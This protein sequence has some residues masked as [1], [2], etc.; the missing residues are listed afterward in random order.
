[1]LGVRCS[2][3]P[4]LRSWILATSLLLSASAS[5]SP[6]WWTA[7]SVL[8]TN[9]VPNDYAAVNQGQAKWMAAQAAGELDRLLPGG[10][11]QAVSNLLAGFTASGNDLPLNLGQLKALAAPFYDRI[12]A[13]G[14]IDALPEDLPGPY[15]WTEAPSDDNDFAIANIG[16]LKRVFGFDLDMCFDT[17]NDGLP[18]G[19]ELRW[20]LDIANPADAAAPSTH[21]WAHGLTN[22]QVFRYPGVLVAPAHSTAGDG[23]PDRWKASL[24]LDAN[25]PSLAAGD[26][27]GD[28][29]TLKVEYDRQSHPGIDDRVAFLI[30]TS[31]FSL[32]WNGFDT[33]A[34]TTPRVKYSTLVQ[35]W[36]A[37]ITNGQ[38]LDHVSGGSTVLRD[39]R[40]G[41]DTVRGWGTLV[42]TPGTDLYGGGDVVREPTL[43]IQD[44]AVWSIFEWGEED[45]DGDGIPDAEGGHEQ[46]DLIGDN[47]S[48]QTLTQVYTSEAFW[49][50]FNSWF[51]ALPGQFAVTT[52]AAVDV[53]SLSTN[54]N[55]HSGKKVQ[56]KISLDSSPHNRF[57]SWMEIFTPWND[58]AT[59]ENESA[60]PEYTFR[61]WPDE[62]H[63][64]TGQE[65]TP[66]YTIDPLA[67]APLRVGTYDLR[68]FPSCEVVPD[69]DRNGAITDADRLSRRRGNPLRIWVNDD[70]DR[71]DD[72]REAFEDAP[73]GSY[74]PGSMPTDV[75]SRSMNFMDQ[76]VNGLRDLVDF[77]PVYLDFPFDQLPPGAYTYWLKQQDSAV[78]YVYTS[79]K[80][81]EVRGVHTNAVYG[82]GVNSDTR[83][84]SAL[85]YWPNGQAPL[86]A[87]GP[88]FGPHGPL[89]Q[90][91]LAASNRVLMI[92]GS[93][94]STNPIV[95]EVRRGADLVLSC[96]MA[97]S[98]SSVRDMFR[99]LNV[100]TNDVLFTEP[101]QSLLWTPFT[102]DVAKVGL[103]PTSLSEPANLPD[104]AYG[105]PGLPRKTLVAI[106]GVNW[107]ENETPAGHAEV[108]KRFFQS[109]SNARFI[110]VSWA[111]DSGRRMGQPMIYYTD[112]IGAFVASHYVKEGL[113]GFWGT[114]TMIFAHSL[115]NVL[116]SSMIADHGLEV[117]NY[118]MI[119][120][121]VPIEAYDGVPAMSEMMKMTP[122]DWRVGP[123]G[124]E[125][126]R[127]P[128]I[129]MA[130]RWHS[131]FTSPDPRRWVGWDD[132]FA[133]VASGIQV[134]NFYSS[135]EDVLKGP[136]PDGALPDLGLALGLL[137][138]ALNG[139]LPSAW[140]L[141]WAMNSVYNAEQTWVYSEMTKGNPGR[142]ADFALL[143]H[144]HGGWAFRDSSL[145]DTNTPIA[146]PMFGA[147]EARD[148]RCKLWDKASWLY[149][150]DGSADVQ[151]RLSHYPLT[152]AGTDT[153]WLNRIKNHAKLLAEAIP[154]LSGPVGGS[155]LDKVKNVNM[156][157]ACRDAAFWPARDEVDKPNRWL[158]GD[159]KNPAYAYVYRLYDQCTRIIEGASP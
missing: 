128:W 100:R 14:F 78:K 150:P 15:P 4:L 108:F 79:L 9:A 7:R 152:P 125:V 37:A 71:S 28:G 88:S 141:R 93:A 19:I 36:D 54:V 96:Q 105:E 137:R 123:A 133:A 62:T 119:N 3:F 74:E 83:L 135:Q 39:R 50:N 73:A 107:D 130:A 66:V 146:G 21:P 22:L 97:L 49:Q 55:L 48:T 111:S 51:P 143:P 10:A 16:Q 116:A 63:N 65:E 77:F 46:V 11:G 47:A 53:A 147:F 153:N 109:G 114:N 98:V 42:P 85:S 76:R 29:Y 30:D 117:G 23:I 121:A 110:G 68:L 84:D 118:F 149:A 136:R 104:G 72:S 131:Q 12:H 1:M 40:T 69:F 59:P 91:W 113:A 52:T 154:S 81:S 102:H 122:A 34:E 25:D 43:L 129:S 26:A 158:H 148:D 86:W 35:A 33:F 151:A 24:G 64:D 115:G 13:E 82:C 103:W 120:A 145:R 139:L 17:D 134:H 89:D 32:K 75:A 38:G 132:R 27:D 80:P 57:V 41:A 124:S 156:H 144:V 101:D 140:H 56:Y 18:D 60:S 5:D 6:H 138:D 70:R 90:N 142:L 2:V 20:G 67:N 44:A 45:W 159:Y 106:H 61:H 112:V 157:S 127:F 8:D 58:P 126:N 155:P 94:I 87:E 95:F 92:E 99:Y 31:A